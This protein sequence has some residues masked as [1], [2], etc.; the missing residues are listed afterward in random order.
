MNLHG[1]LKKIPLLFGVKK[2][3]YVE[4]G[5]TGHPFINHSVLTLTIESCAHILQS[6]A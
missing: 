3:L 5:L 1:G 4:R 6:D 2:T